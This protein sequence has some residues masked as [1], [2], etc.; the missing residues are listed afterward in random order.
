M[1]N[2]D[3]NAPIAGIPWNTPPPATLPPTFAPLPKEKSNTYI[4]FGWFLIIFSLVGL[5]FF[6]MVSKILRL[7]KTTIE[8]QFTSLWNLITTQLYKQNIIYSIFPKDSLFWPIMGIVIV[9]A[10]INGVAF[11]IPEYSAKTQNG[12]EDGRNVRNVLLSLY[13]IIIF[14]AGAYVFISIK[15]NTFNSIIIFIV[16]LMGFF[17]S[18]WGLY[19]SFS[20]VSLEKNEMFSISLIMVIYGI[21]GAVIFGY[22]KQKGIDTFPIFSPIVISIILLTAVILFG[23][24]FTKDKNTSQGEFINISTNPI[25]TTNL[26]CIDILGTKT[27]Q[28]GWNSENN[29]RMKFTLILNNI[30]FSDG[31]YQTTKLIAINDTEALED[32][33]VL[34][35]Y[36]RDDKKVELISKNIDNQPTSA[37]VDIGDIPT[38]PPNQDDEC[39]FFENKIDIFVNVTS[40]SDVTEDIGIITLS[41]NQNQDSVFIKK[42]YPSSDWGSNTTINVSFTEN[43]N[44]TV[45]IPIEG[46]QICQPSDKISFNDV[47]LVYQI[48]FIIVV[49]ALVFVVVWLIGVPKFREAMFGFDKPE[50][51]FKDVSEPFT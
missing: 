50:Y 33:D 43:N 26:N 47:P 12:L 30:P 16:L 48:F 3:I 41:T 1:S 17:L 20:S 42:S 19:D 9:G 18:T 28:I 45:V 14:M 21:F 29:I 35:V 4:G 7:P 13:A 2:C 10:L 11:L 44:G 37:I 46:F 32:S 27:T 25:L 39:Q 5:P 40:F 49:T 6:S 38:P 51:S 23:I 22:R 15:F 8:N 34:S 36:Y 31:K 24:S